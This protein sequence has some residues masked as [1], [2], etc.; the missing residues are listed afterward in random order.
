MDDDELTVAVCE[1]LEA[2]A[3][4]VFATAATGSQVQIV[5]GDVGAAGVDRA[6]G[7]Q[8]YNGLDELTEGPPI[9]FVQL[10]IRGAVRDRRSAN[11]IAATA[12]DALHGLVSTAGIFLAERISFARL[13][14]DGNG[15]D[16]RSENYQLT[17]HS[18]EG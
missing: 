14:S 2:R 5:Y 13:G 16:E 6:V 7:V 9:R 18:L 11:Q 8:V 1:V 15:R 10:R 17:L 12:F 3:V 4:G